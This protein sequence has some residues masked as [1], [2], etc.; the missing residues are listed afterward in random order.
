MVNKP[1]LARFQGS[2]LPSESF[3]FSYPPGTALIVSGSL[4][5]VSLAR[6]HGGSG[7]GEPGV[8]IGRISG[9]EN[10]RSLR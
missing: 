1:S 2:R 7:S 9:E 4:T 5:L 8:V 3:S 6:A 10:G